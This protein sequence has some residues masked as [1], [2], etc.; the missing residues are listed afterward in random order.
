MK[1]GEKRASDLRGRTTGCGCATHALGTQTCN[2]IFTAFCLAIIIAFHFVG[3]RVIADELD[4]DY[5]QVPAI[6]T[7]RPSV[8]G[9]RLLGSHP[10]AQRIAFFGDSTSFDNIG[11]GGEHMN[12]RRWL[13]HQHHGHTP[14]T[15]LSRSSNF[16][17][18][19]G[20]E[21]ML[22]GSVTEVTVPKVPDTWLPPGHHFAVG[23]GWSFY[24]NQNGPTGLVLRLNHRNDNAATMSCPWQPNGFYHV[25]EAVGQGN[26]AFA[27]GSMQGGASLIDVTA[28]VRVEV[29][30]AA[31]PNSSPRV[32]WRYFPQ[33][34]SGFCAP[35]MSD[36]IVQSGFLFG[37][38]QSLAQPW[39]AVF[40]TET[41]PL[42]P[43]H[44]DQRFYRVGLTGGD[45]DP[46][47][48]AQIIGARFISGNPKG[49]ITDSFSTG[50]YTA[51]SVVA[52]HPFCGPA[53][54]AGG[55]NVAWIMYGLND[56]GLGHS[57]AT[58]EADVRT[59]I[60]FI[61]TSMNDPA[62]PVVLE[63]C[64]FRQD[65]T[66]Q[67]KLYAAALYAIAQDT[68][69]ILFINTRKLIEE[70]YGW[71]SGSEQSY[72]AD[73]VHFTN[74]GAEAV[75]RCSIDT[76]IAYLTSASKPTDFARQPAGW[77]GKDA[78]LYSTTPLASSGN[79]TTITVGSRG[80]QRVFR[81]LLTFD[82][83]AELPKGAEI[84][85]ATLSLTV[86]SVAAAPALFEINRCTLPQWVEGATGS[87][88]ASWNL[89]S[90][91]P[92]LP[93]A[94]PGGDYSTNG[95]AAGFVLPTTAGG[96]GDGST[97]T[98]DVTALA[99][100]AL[101]ERS[102]VL[103]LLIKR[104][105]ETGTDAIAY[106]YSS[107]HP[108]PSQRPKLRL[109]YIPPRLLSP[110]CTGDCSPAWGDAMVNVNDLIAVISAWGPYNGPADVSPAGGD[111]IVNV[112]DLLNVINHWGACVD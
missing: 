27:T 99:Q 111:G 14:G 1:Q 47:H 15:Q 60:Q 25:P 83:L 5:T 34:G 96:F 88:G 13:W 2:A 10:V 57:A 86:S 64:T 98:F 107:D 66:A 91:N 39:G 94:A 104:T 51:N 9:D 67:A 101:I 70:R 71:G 62:F 16:G 73:G 63:S 84:L 80:T 45:T 65:E 50:G 18:T 28:G 79:T 110:T 103:A 40:R 108:V 92:P 54:A 87:D 11:Y 74:F 43:L 24:Y 61:R 90:A 33:L 17:S 7:S 46:A 97:M 32:I 3:V 35:T 8:F 105:D 100:D 23:G 36:T 53:L 85:S 48:A 81:T 30:A 58:F 6:F 59:L 109:N 55:Y 49:L 75:A 72:L 82:D 56:G 31:H 69:N 44:D 112:A 19:P 37:G 78:T 12:W 29:L 95:Q 20:A 93:W 89:Y 102:G 76:V 106:F 77:R 41:P 4:K 42:L 26:P 52:N 22:M 68:D 38:R 21:W